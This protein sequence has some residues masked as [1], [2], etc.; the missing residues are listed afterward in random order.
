MAHPA[1]ASVGLQPGLEIWRIQV[2]FPFRYLNVAYAHAFI[3]VSLLQNF[4]PVPVPKSQYGKFH[5]GDSYIV[6]KTTLNS[7]MSWDIHFWLGAQ[8]T[9]DE[10]GT[11]AMMSV[12]LDDALGGAA[13]QHREVQGH[14]S[15]QF[16]SY[17]QPAIRYLEGGHESGFSHVTTNA[18]AEKKLYQ[19]KGRRNLRVSQVEPMVASM[20]RGDCFVLSS[21]SSVYVYVG[22]QARSVERLKAIAVAN[23]I[24]TQDH[25]GRGVLEVIDQCHPCF[26]QYSSDVDVADFFTA[27]GSGNAEEVPEAEAGGDDEVCAHATRRAR[28]VARAISNRHKSSTNTY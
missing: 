22:E 3:A 8:T 4:T 13:V 21:G 25:N 27:L 12:N 1:F 9:Q 17:F 19:I 14:E 7:K 16:L 15:G 10:A 6:L 20:N 2:L 11:A 26:D 28:N 23:Q 5:S 18:G 24:R